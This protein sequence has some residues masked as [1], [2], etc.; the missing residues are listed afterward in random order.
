VKHE[1]R[2][3]FRAM[4]TDITVLAVGSAGSRSLPRL[5]E[6]VRVLFERE[7]QRF[8]RFRADSELSRLNAA[9]GSLAPSGPLCDV[10]LRAERW[11]QTT[12]GVFDPRIL[13]ALERA[14]Y[15]RTFIE[16]VS[17]GARPA[18]PI[19]PDERP[20]Q[21]D[22]VLDG[23]RREVRLTG[24]A[25]LDLGGIVKGWSVDRAVE[26][27]APLDSF[28][29][30]AGGDLA[31][32]GDGLYGPGWWVAVEDACDPTSDRAVV[33]VRDASVATSGVYRRRWRGPNGHS[34]HHLI[35]SATG[36]PVSNPVL[37]VTVMGP[38]TESCDILAKTALI[39]GP[40][41][42]NS[43]LEEWS[44]VEG[45]MVLTDGGERATSG[46]ADLVQERHV[47]P[48]DP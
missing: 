23:D 14:G 37:S 6:T 18:C 41:M 24:G 29:V 44:G 38:D 27:L 42:G 5:L 25:R 2:L 46:W 13:P 43:L 34:A 36:A 30:D 16:V 8:S 31:A 22:F 15:D 11:R 17:A 48:I 10:L 21:G 3:E 47:L 12:N 26:L 35:D 1:Y 32:R 33:Q 45:Y 28:L 4:G 40:E 39:L 19:A 9:G 7:E 20:R